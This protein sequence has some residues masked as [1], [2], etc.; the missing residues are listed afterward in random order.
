MGVA[1]GRVRTGRLAW[2]T[3]A[4]VVLACSG[5]SGAIP[6]GPEVVTS[7]QRALRYEAQNRRIF[8]DSYH[9]HGPHDAAWNAAAEHA[10]D[11]MSQTWMYVAMPPAIKVSREDAA[12][13]LRQA[14]DAG[15]DDPI[16]LGAMG[17]LQYDLQDYKA[18]EPLL[19][20]SLDVFR[21]GDYPAILHLWTVSYLAQLPDLK[22]RKDVRKRL[23]DEAIAA[24]I[25]AFTSDFF[26]ADDQQLI[27]H[28]I[29]LRCIEAWSFDERK[30]F[31]EAFTAA[32]ADVDPWL[33]HYLHGHF[34]VDQAWKYRTSAWAHKVTPEQWKK[35]G[36]TLEVARQ[37]L[38]AAHRLHPEWPEAAAR[39]I[40]VAMAGATP[41]QSPRYWFDAAVKA[42]FD[43]R[44][45]YK[46]L[47]WALRPRWGGSYAQMVALGQE[48]VGTGRFDTDVPGTMLAVYRDLVSELGDSHERVTKIPTLFGALDHMFEGYAKSEVLSQRARDMNQSRR[49][50]LSWRFGRYNAAGKMLRQ[51]GDRAQFVEFKAF[52]GDPAEAPGE[53]FARSGDVAEATMQADDLLDDGEYDRA[54]EA[55]QKLA[56]EH[57]D[58]EPLARYLTLR[59]DEAAKLSDF[60]VGRRVAIQPDADYHHWRIIDGRWDH[61]S[62][63]DTIGAGVNTKMHTACNIDFGWRF[64][65]TGEMDFSNANSS[66]AVSTRSDCRCI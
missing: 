17:L 32:E 54:S 31:D 3:L 53:C 60:H 50:A 7:W 44:P 23:I 34:L 48:C 39:L 26:N 63:G 11:Q 16:V 56:R 51:L 10:L 13:A 65:L 14:I 28:N 18:A 64:E 9:A 38:V 47:R 12:A 30:R 21:K 22:W 29:G 40:P 4:V 58:V 57:A 61:D 66:P 8:I 6:A 55:Y 42:Q 2:L 49:A 36:E 15:C 5:V 43:Y 62:L 41:N 33:Y 46:S 20:K 45:A 19:R 52:G 27:A 25:K 24:S 37:H 1:Q 35:F 59:A